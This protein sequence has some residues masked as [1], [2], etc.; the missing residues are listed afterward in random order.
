MLHP[1]RRNFLGTSGL[2]LLA[3]GVAIGQ[4]KLT[5]TLKETLEKGLKCRRQVEFAFVAQVVT[6]VDNS[7]LPQ[8]VVLG[9]FSWARKQREDIP[10]PYFQFALRERA[11]K[12]G[13]S[14]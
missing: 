4:E 7:Q 2:W 12:Y 3:G 10:F 13:V 14:L 9:T 6:L 8:D 11:K 5:P 1:T